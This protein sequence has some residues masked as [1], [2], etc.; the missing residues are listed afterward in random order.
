MEEAMENN[1]LSSQKALPKDNFTPLD[2][3]DEKN[4][5]KN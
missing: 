2:K 4:E 3:K 1:P 5:R